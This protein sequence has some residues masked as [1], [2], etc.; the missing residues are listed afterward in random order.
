MVEAYVAIEKARFEDRLTVLYDIDPDA[1]QKKILPLTIQPLLENAI[2]HGVMKHENGGTV[3]LT[4]KLEGD[5]VHV[6]VWD[7]GVGINQDQLKNLWH[8][9]YS[10]SQRRGVGLANIQ[11]RLMYFC[12]EELKVT[13][14]EGEWT[15]VQFNFQG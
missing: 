13:S 1:L 3:R 9:E 7:N 5:T 6:E 8:R 4:V 10:S 14:I 11:H 12:R 15:R 2:R